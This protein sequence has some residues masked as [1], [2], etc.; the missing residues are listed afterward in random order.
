MIQE[1]YVSE[2]TQNILRDFGFNSYERDFYTDDNNHSHSQ[3]LVNSPI[4]LA[5]AQNWLRYCYKIHTEATPYAHE[6][7]IYYAYKVLLIID[8]KDRLVMNRRE[9]AGFKTYEDAIDA[10]IRYSA[11][12]LVS[13]KMRK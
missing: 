5:V 2:E 4:P 11:T 13:Y 6:D 10:A 8:G 9:R 12:E 7:G 3:M 1:A